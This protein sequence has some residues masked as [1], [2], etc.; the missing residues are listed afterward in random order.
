M[1]RGSGGRK[2]VGMVA[3]AALA[4]VLCAGV[5]VPGAFSQGAAAKPKTEAEMKSQK[6]LIA[7]ATYANAFRRVASADPDKA[8]TTFGNAGFKAKWTADAGKLFKS[9]AQKNILKDIFSASVVLVGRASATEAV[10]GL[11]SPWLDAVVLLGM[12][13]GKDGK[14]HMTDYRF[15]AGESWRNE[16]NVDAAKVASLYTIKD[17][18]IDVLIDRYHRTVSVFN[19]NYPLEAPYK[20][21]PDRLESR[22]GT[23]TEESTP[24]LARRVCRLNMYQSYFSK[25]NLGLI[26]SVRVLRQEI[27]AGDQAR[28]RAFLSPKQDAEMLKTICTLPVDLRDGVVTTYYAADKEAAVIALV[29]EAS[30]RWVFVAEVTKGAAERNIHL[31]VLDLETSTELVAAKKGGA[32]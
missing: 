5:L 14:V 13:V 25:G 12:N 22:I 3:A 32:R 9:K 1:K 19:E 28:L 30:P 31:D 16:K 29:D 21:V 8:V 17:P 23:T 10:A 7:F 26:K 11:Y 15:V 24:M 2:T 6:T 4:L 18:L 27:K 20:L